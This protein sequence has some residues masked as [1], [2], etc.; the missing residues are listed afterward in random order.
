MNKSSLLVCAASDGELLLEVHHTWKTCTKERKWTHSLRHHVSIFRGSLLRISS[1]PEKSLK[2]FLSFTPAAF[3]SSAAREI[4]NKK[5]WKLEV[6][7][8]VESCEKVMMRFLAC[9][10]RW[11]K[12]VIITI[13]RTRLLLFSDTKVPLFCSFHDLRAEG[14]FISLP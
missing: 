5:E 14:S 11:Q 4:N 3:F 13:L 9:P 6:A 1:G 12:T 7:K 10:Q 2:H 8:N